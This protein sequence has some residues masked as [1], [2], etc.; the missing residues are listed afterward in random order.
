MLNPDGVS[1]GYW[2]FDTLGLNLNRYYKDP[3]IEAHPTI[4]AAKNAIIK[5]HY[6]NGLRMYVDF[7][8]HCTKRGCFIFGNTLQDQNLQYEAMMIPKLMSLNSVNFDF[9]ECNF[10]DDKLNVKDKKGDCR[11][12]SGRAAIFRETNCNPFTYT[13]ETNYVT[14]HRMNT[15]T[16]R[17]DLIN[18]KKI[19]KEDS[20][21]HDTTSSL[22]RGRK[23]PVFTP[24]VLFDVGQSLLI[25]VLDY[26]LKNP[27]TRL[28]KKKGDTLEAAVIKIRKDLQKADEKPSIGQLKKKLGVGKKKKFAQKLD[29]VQLVLHKDQSIEDQFANMKLKE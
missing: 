3:Q 22:Y 24:D 4:W 23:S 13:F 17:Y 14:G 29:Q 19:I 2:R 10:Q 7:H 9:R 25:A 16:P 21:V 27:M 5:E 28:I 20:A 15:L 6:S 26:D 11:D 8:A 18:D 1:R 12:G